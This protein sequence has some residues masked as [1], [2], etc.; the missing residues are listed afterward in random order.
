MEQLRAINRHLRR[1]IDQI[2]EGI[3]ILETGPIREPGPRI[4][5]LNRG[6]L[7]LT[8]YEFVDLLG[9]PVASLYDPERLQDLLVRLP[10]VAQ[11][12]KAYQIRTEL[13]CRN[14]TTKDCL[15]KISAACDESGRAVNF[16][17]SIK[18]MPSEQWEEVSAGEPASAEA[19]DAQQ[20]EV[21]VRVIDPDEVPAPT[22]NTE[23]A[24]RDEDPENVSI[25]K[26][27]MYSLAMA[28]GGIAHDFKNVLTS[29]SANLSLAKLEAP[30][31]TP[32]REH[33]DD[34]ATAANGATDLTDRLLSYAKGGETDKIA[35]ADVGR[36]LQDAAKLS[37]YGA[38]VECRLDIPE[39]LWSASIDYTQITQVVNNLI[40]NARQAMGESGVIQA[41]LRNANIRAFDPVDLRPGKYV[42]LSVI[43]H[44]CGIPP[45]HLK[46]IFKSFYTT[47]STGTGLGLATC[48]SIVLKHQ[49]IITVESDV[50]H[51]TEFN[52]YLPATGEVAQ[53]GEEIAEG[54]VYPGE[55]TVLIVDDLQQVRTVASALLST[56][57]YEVL[58]AESGE[59]ALKI[60]K[61]CGLEGNPVSA[62]LMDMTLPGGMCGRE[63]TREILRHDPFAKVIA[64][65]GYFDDSDCD[66]FLELGFSCVVSKPYDLQK[67]SHTLHKTLSS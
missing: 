59:E 25:Q 37:T 9:Q 24:P 14:G 41:S 34:A 8:G 40:I 47:K 27:R 66:Q 48:F 31:G 52:V 64:T 63:T 28:A 55:G 61:R 10:A 54:K 53:R 36:L 16:I 12:G 7:A 1:A 67:L 65:S 45:E 56:L 23:A 30:A 60:Y 62:V 18:E 21:E 42:K 6:L 33:L 35:A 4:V 11:K 51:G 22:G 13:C 50:G 32:L 26:S 39:D 5:F 46:D 3:I 17:F 57:G 38:Q 29:I 49:G 15:W 58:L 2:D 19:P 44:G 20:S 43:D